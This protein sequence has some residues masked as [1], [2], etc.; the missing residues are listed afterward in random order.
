MTATARTERGTTGRST[1]DELMEE[2][3]F[4]RRSLEDLD[5][6]RAAGD[7]DTADYEALRVSYEG[8]WRA[9]E[10]ILQDLDASGVT[11]QPE[12]A[13]PETAGDAKRAPGAR[14]WLSSRR[15]RLLL[16][17][18]A[19]VCFALAGTL[20][21]LA[22]ADVEPFAQSPPLSLA[23]QIRI[24]LGEAG[25]LAANHEIVQAVSVYDK[26]LELDPQQPEALANGGWL[27]RLAGLSSRSSR[28]VTAGDAEI[29]T[30]VK[31][32]PGYALAR[33]Y[34]AIALYQDEH[35]AG[36]AVSEF[37]AMLAD[38]PSATLSASVRTVA[39]AAYSA[40]GVALPPALASATG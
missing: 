11:D 33:A 34:D 39:S 25:T 7:L 15:H 3:G 31:V 19:A 8:R 28:L 13:Q 2:G 4:L 18:S 5:R 22:L 6:E 21:G 1:R 12:A 27:V 20:V 29:A 35:S 40:A 26:V 38:Q 10:A 16:G 37:K 23:T 9:I 14:S 30:A 17:W 32:A 24:E 36:A